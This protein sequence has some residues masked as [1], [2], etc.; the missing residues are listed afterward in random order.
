MK[1]QAPTIR[2]SSCRKGRFSMNK[3]GTDVE[4]NED[5][6]EIETDDEEENENENKYHNYDKDHEN[7]NENNEGDD[8]DNVLEENNEESANEDDSMYTPF[9]TELLPL[10]ERF[11]EIK[12]EQLE[13]EETN[14]IN[15]NRS[16]LDVQ[17]LRLITPS[18]QQKAMAYGVR[19]CNNNNQEI[20]FSRLLLCRV[21]SQ[22]NYYNSSKLIYLMESKNSNQNMFNNNV[23]FRDNG[24]ISIGTFFRVV[25]PLPIENKRRGDIPLIKTHIPLIV[26]K[27]PSV[28]R[29]IRIRKEIGNLNSLAFILVG[30]NIY[31]NRSTAIKTTCGGLLCDKQRCSDW[32]GTRGC[33]CYNFRDDISNIA[34]EHSVFFQYGN[35]TIQHHD[36]SSTKFSSYYLTHRLP[37]TVTA[38]ALTMTQEYFDIE[39][40]I[41]DVIGFV[42]E[43]GGWTVIGWYKRGIITDKSLLE[44][45]PS[46]VVSTEVASG[47]INYHIVQL[48]PT[49][50]EFMNKNSDLYFQLQQKKYDTSQMQQTY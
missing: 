13:G 9:N 41:A 50:N 40:A 6:V 37:S 8:D 16:F 11:N 32:N 42:N 18:S 33:G 12:I 48:L 28:T 47:L 29:S 26:M 44:V 1:R 30:M 35:D 7:E 23:E 34:F 5:N 49:N 27:R 25:T 17:L 2:S 20:I 19:R 21:H 15:L 38:S 43:N 45:P 3:N 10:M 4:D 24:V 14:K 22:N 39:E 36:F 31:I 46:N